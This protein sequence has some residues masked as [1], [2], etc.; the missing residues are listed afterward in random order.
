MKQGSKWKRFFLVCA[1]VCVAGIICTVIGVT[2]GG[3]DDFEKVAENIDWIQTGPGERG[4]TSY[5]VDKFDAVQISGDAD[6]YL[7]GKEFYKNASRL[8][9]D[10]VLNVT[11]T[12]VLGANKVIVIAGDKVPQP[13]IEVEGKTL[14]II[15]MPADTDG[16]NL[17]FSHLTWSPTILVCCPMQTLESLKLDTNFG[18]F[19]ALGTAWKNAD[20]KLACGYTNMEGVTSGGLSLEMTTSDADLQ[21]EFLK[22]TFI[23]VQDGDLQLETALGKG[24]Y[25]LD[26]TT[27]SGD[28]TVLEA[29]K[30]EETEDEIFGE[31]KQ[32]GGP[33]TITMKA[34]S[35]D[36][37]LQFGSGS[38]R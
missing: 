13:K 11:E 12:D 15:A 10:D 26:L 33:H 22:R 35:G 6:V 31:Y 9:E 38:D 2:S 4:I 34:E 17:D 5:P 27:D 29:G 25:G 21:G 14:Q 18:D 8:V 7:L 36:M 32:N 30:E 23:D 1:A 28:I 19:Q 24:E 16:V 20:I 3:I 37:T